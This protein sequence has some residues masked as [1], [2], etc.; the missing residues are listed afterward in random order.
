M[1][2]NRHKNPEQKTLETLKRHLKGGETL[3]IGVSGGSDSVFLLEIL[4]KFKPKLNIIVAHL[5]HT[6]RGVDADLDTEFVKDLAKKHN[7]ECPCT[8]FNIAQIA[9]THKKSLEETGRDQRYTFFRKLY[10]EKKADFILTAHHSDDNLETIL[11]N[12]TRGATL[13]GL[14]GMQE[15]SEDKS[16]AKLLRPLLHVSK[17][18]I[19]E[20]L[21]TNHILYR[22]D[23]S[24]E[25]TTIPR[26]FIR[27]TIIPDLK[28][29]NP[30]LPQTVLKNAENLREIQEFLEESAKTWISRHNLSEPKT[31]LEKFNLPPLQNKPP[32]LQKEILRQIYFQKEGTTKNIEKIHLDEIVAIIQKNVGRKHKSLGKYKVEIKQGI[33]IMTPCRTSPKTTSRT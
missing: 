11:F 23:V 13:Q 7:L 8:H 14:S 9:S 18:E 19:I 28:T 30:A 15:V 27:H 1:P 20:H 25:D 4:T 10:K 6:L 5:N 21:K 17:E 26:N 32:A 16:G 31:K 22:E 3:I 29:L 33:L 2:R 24:N 12:F